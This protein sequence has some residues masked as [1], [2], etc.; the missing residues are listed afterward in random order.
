MYLGEWGSAAGLCHELRRRRQ[1]NRRLARSN[2]GWAS[3]CKTLAST[4]KNAGNLGCLGD[5]TNDEMF[6]I[7]MT[8]C[9]HIDFGG[10]GTR[11]QQCWGVNYDEHGFLGQRSMSYKGLARAYKNADDSALLMGTMQFLGNARS[12]INFL[13]ITAKINVVYNLTWP[14]KMAKLLRSFRGVVVENDVVGQWSGAGGAICEDNFGL[15]I[16]LRVLSAGRRTW[17]TS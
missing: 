6:K 7:C 16:G 5:R 14:R 9:A 17:E 1:L 13:Q 2:S 8:V 4:G 15:E 3:V 12:V 11:D 10:P